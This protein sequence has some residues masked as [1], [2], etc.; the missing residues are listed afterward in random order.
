MPGS[1]ARWTASKSSAPS[2]STEKRV[3]EFSDSRGIANRFISLDDALA[4]G[5]FDAA[6]NVTPDRIHHPTT[7]ALIAAGKP[8]LC[9]KPL[10]ENFEKASEMADAADGPASSTW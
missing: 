3:A 10:A 7:M 1:S 6:V 2:T 5:K 4:W 8:V 9:E